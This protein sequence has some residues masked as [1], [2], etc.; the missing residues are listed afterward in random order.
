[1][2]QKYG[3][4]EVIKKGAFVIFDEGHNIEDYAEE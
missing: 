1:M 2:R 3:L 4:E